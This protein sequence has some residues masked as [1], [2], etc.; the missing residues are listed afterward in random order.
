LF[1][2]PIFIY[3]LVSRYFG[4]LKEANGVICIYTCSPVNIKFTV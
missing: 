2:N 3:S 4:I 1:N